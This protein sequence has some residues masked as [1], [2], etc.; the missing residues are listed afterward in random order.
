MLTH[1]THI[2]LNKTQ[3]IPVDTYI[4]KQSLPF[5]TQPISPFNIE[6]IPL[7]TQP[8]PFNIQQIPL[9]TQPVPLNKQL[10]PLNT[11]PIPFNTQPIPLNTQPIP[12]NTQPIPL[13]TQ[14]IPLNTQPIPLNTQPIP[15]NTQPIPLNTIHSQYHPMYIQVSRYHYTHTHTADTTQ[16]PYIK[17]T[18][19][20]YTSYLQK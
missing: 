10:M 3:T 9:N 13:N 8:I 12:L 18:I 14:P 11:Q 1:T 4:N 15:L 6:L 20:L 7:H 2:T 5:N 19:Q 17:Y 16:F